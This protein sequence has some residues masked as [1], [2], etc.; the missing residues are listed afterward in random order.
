MA[1]ALV[2]L[3][4]AVLAGRGKGSLAPA[5]QAIGEAGT[6][7]GTALVRDPASLVNPFI[8]TAG[9]AN[10]FPGADA[11]FG[12]VQW[13]PDTPSQP[14]GGGYAYADSEITGFSL[15]HLSGPGCKAAG[16]IPVL[17]TTG[18]TA[19]AVSAAARD[20]FSHSGEAADAGYYK[21]ALSNG[22]TTELTATTRT[23]MARFGFPAGSQANLVIKLDGSQDADTATSFAAL[24]ATRVAGSVTSGG[25]CGSGNRYT[26]YFVLEFSRPFTSSGTFFPSGRNSGGG[27]GG[28]SGPASAYLTFLSAPGKLLVKAGVSYVSADGAAANLAA[29]NPGWNF[30]ATRAATHAAWDRL[31]SR[32]RIGGGTAA[33]QQVFY[34]A[35]YHSL[36]HPNVFSDTDRRYRGTDGRIHTVD[37][38][39]SAFYTNVSGWDIYR[40]QAQLEALADPAAASDT[41]QS[42]L[43][44]DEQ[45]GMLPKWPEN[46]GESY[47]MA[48]DPADA[49]I[50][51]YWAFG[52]R[53]FA[54]RR[55]LAAMVTQASR[56]SR[57]R[58]GLTY[59][60]RLGYLPVNGR[61]GCCDY[62]GSVS[63][64]LEYDT[65]DFAVSAL[66]D[67]LGEPGIRREF[68]A[69]AQ[70][71]RNLLDPATGFARPRDAD[72]NWAAGFTPASHTGFVEGDSWAYTGMVPF[73]LAGLAAVKGGD[74]AMAAYLNSALG[75]G[76]G[77]PGRADLGNEPSIGLPWEYDYIGEPWRT[78]AA[79]RRIVTRLWSDT[80]AGLGAGND[81]LGA[82]SAWYVWAAL[83]M[84]PATPGT[85]DL[86]LSTPEFP[87][88]VLTLGSGAQLAI[89]TRGPAGSGYVASAAWNGTRWDRAYAPPAALTHGGTLSFTLGGRPD[90]SWAA[91]PD[92]APVSYGGGLG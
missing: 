8:G 13:S 56:P 65:A 32:V 21:V 66:A 81:D 39:H 20:A 23:G 27:S 84:Y 35:L 10:D 5:A 60:R 83:G 86:A 89:G 76:A 12:M 47:E 44:D 85:A 57:I 26:L 33:S 70:D 72:G 46:N 71:W 22:V 63:A 41:A 15:T 92:A 31:L 11:P 19:G 36:L 77:T 45:D 48:G 16:D 90:R 18:A 40:T 50:A 25:F 9:D 68:A 14:D 74:R 64:T 34:T 80:P 1:A 30:D 59:L 7:A 87:R 49:I 67:D 79:V 54:A 37:A 75:S 58:P 88:A 78:Q 82:M 51:D 91:G 29:E 53:N 42:L 4:V 17:P 43:D 24:S 61:Y 28:G 3:A 6:T 38:G 55:A 73:D 62:Y 69:R 52:A 2:L